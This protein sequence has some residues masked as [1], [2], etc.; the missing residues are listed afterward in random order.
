MYFLE[1]A[2]VI[3]LEITVINSRNLFIYLNLPSTCP[4]SDTSFGTSVLRFRFWKSWNDFVLLRSKYISS[5]S[6]RFVIISVFGIYRNEFGHRLGQ[7]LIENLGRR[8][9]R[10]PLFGLFNNFLL[11]SHY[12]KW[13]TVI[14]VKLYFNFYIIKSKWAYPPAWNWL[15]FLVVIFWPFKGLDLV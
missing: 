14:I 11:L 12:Y 3:E 15:L 10:P 13:Q 9:R 1:T 4:K 6:N 7:R 2:T 8:P 5:Y